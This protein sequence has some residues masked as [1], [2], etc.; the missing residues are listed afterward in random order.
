[1]RQA[2]KLNPVPTAWVTAHARM[3]APKHT[4]PSLTPCVGSPSPARC[5]ASHGSAAAQQRQVAAPASLLLQLLALQPKQGKAEKS[6]GMAA[7]AECLAGSPARS[8]THRL[9]SHTTSKPASTTPPQPDSLLCAS[10]RAASS[11]RL[12]NSSPRSKLGRPAAANAAAAAASESRLELS[13]PL[14]LP[15]PRCCAVASGG[16]LLAAP[17]PAAS[18][19]KRAR[20]AW[21][22]AAAA[23][24]GASPCGGSRVS[25]SAAPA[26]RA[27]ARRCCSCQPGPSQRGA[28]QA[29]H[30]HRCQPCLWMAWWRPHSPS[31]SADGAM[32][33][34]S[35]TWVSGRCSSCWVVHNQRQRVSWTRSSR[36]H[37][38]LHP[39]YKD[40]VQEQAEQTSTHGGSSSASK[41]ATPGQQQ[42]QRRRRRVQQH[43]RR[44]YV[45]HRR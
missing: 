22:A 13:L 42:Q 40:M 30:R 29:L 28:P 16:A 11:A 38:A 39:S 43:I 21:A 41:A 32:Q 9:C 1:M 36:D 18:H 27:A 10:M 20:A 26:C 33:V 6:G 25:S 31:L 45:A 17:A 37:D 4:A 7:K 44:M 5:A 24:I 8:R 12:R 15:L 3:H 35:D 23:A 14:P 34:Q 19:R 2:G